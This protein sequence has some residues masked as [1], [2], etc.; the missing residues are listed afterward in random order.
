MSG[1]SNIAISKLK[2]A[3]NLLAPKLLDS[4]K[5]MEDLC[6]AQ[7]GF[8]KYRQNVKDVTGPTIPYIAVHLRDMQYVTDGNPDYLDGEKREKEKDKEREKGDRSSLSD[9]GVS[10]TSELSEG[11]AS[12]REDKFM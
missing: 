6:S 3:K 2:K 7:R 12:E 4:Y 10:E 8:W 9:G 1:L 11:G 5:A